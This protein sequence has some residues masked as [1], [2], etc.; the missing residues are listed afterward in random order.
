MRE[1]II[2]DQNQH[3][4]RDQH[5]EKPIAATRYDILTGPDFAHFWVI[6]LT[7]KVNR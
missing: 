5:P 1:D 6:D 7:W 4:F 3:D 2:H